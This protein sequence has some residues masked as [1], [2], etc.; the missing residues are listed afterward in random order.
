M[1]LIIFATWNHRL[2]VSCTIRYRDPSLLVRAG[3]HSYHRE[4]TMFSGCDNVKHTNYMFDAVWYIFNF[5][6]KIS[7]IS[8]LNA[9]S[10]LHNMSTCI[11]SLFR[12]SMARRHQLT[13]RCAL[14]SILWPIVFDITH[15][16]NYLAIMSSTYL[17]GGRLNVGLLQE[18]A[19]K[20]LLSLLEKCDGP[21]VQVASTW[22]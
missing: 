10:A 7:K 1:S 2:Y 20:Q 15:R 16:S 19:R 5:N 6:I 8:L 14:R 4:A 22:S 21:K 13:S 18:Q 11:P 3:A 9:D 12:R 17:T